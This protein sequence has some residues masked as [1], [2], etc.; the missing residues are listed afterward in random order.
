MKPVLIIENSKNG[1]KLNESASV[2]KE[3][4]YILEGIFTEFDV[5]N[6]NERIY[7]ADEYVPHVNEMMKKK[8]WGVIYGE[9]DHPDVFD[10]SMKYVS[11]TVE[12]AW[13]NKEKNRVDGEI[14]LLNTHYGKDAQSLV[15]D[16]CPVFVSSRAAGVTEANGL[17]KLKQ[18]FTYDI[19]ADPGFSSAR[20]SVKTINESLGFKTNKNF[21]II[22][23]D[24]KS[25][26]MLSE[27]YN[28]ASSMDI[29]TF[30]LSNDLKTEELFKM[31]KNDMIT[32]RQ[33][34]DYTNHLVKQLKANEAKMVKMIKETKGSTQPKKG[35][36]IEDLVEY[37]A[38]I[39]EQLEKM[40]QYM[41]YLAEKVQVSIDTTDVLEKKTDNI[42]KY[43][44]YIAEELDTNIENQVQLNETVKTTIKYTNYLAEN[45][46][47]TIEYSN[48]LAES[49]DQ[50]ID[51]SNYLAESLDQSIDYSQYIA[52]NL[53]NSIKFSNYIAENLNKA[54]DYSE[55]IAES[56]DTTIGYTEYL[57]ESLDANIGYSE[58]IVE[59]LDS[60]INY[61]DYLSECIDNTMDF[62]NS[63]V[64]SLN[65]KG[66]M[67]TEK[68]TTAEQFLTE[69]KKL[70]KK[71]DV[72][73]TKKV[74]PTL[75]KKV[76]VKDTKKV[77]TK[78]DKT[79]IKDETSNQ[80]ITEKIAKLIEEAKKREA[81]K[82]VRPNFY[83]FLIPSDIKAFEDLSND[84]QE[85]IKVA[86]NES[87]GYY[88]RQD[89]IAIMKQV[90]EAD[91]I[92]D[93]ELLIQSMPQKIKKVWEN[94]DGKYKKSILSQSKLYDISTKQLCENFWLT[95]KLEQ[96]NLNEGKTLIASENPFD[97][98]NTLTEEEVKAITNRFKSI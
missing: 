7:T 8:E 12:S 78:V 95:R 45:L 98:I 25:L 44:K 94:L 32:K 9:F 59:Q 69:K 65:S 42:I 34:A 22:E 27:A 19:V 75:S 71:V 52:E 90:L 76:D 96:L 3:N 66:G 15:D 61:A 2:R 4:K 5:R 93:E 21:G 54:I 68:L 36:R 89:V 28:R 87:T 50:S 79:I 91:K 6:R 86:V 48:Y 58:Y 53:D 63:I 14:R 77:D 85:Q 64:E 83:E 56:L 18:L 62:S 26:S 88:S 24:R 55:Y 1:L 82:E 49:L 37:N 73:D 92:T 47:S 30:D 46:D 70:E 38:N 72:K 41:N 67:I 43:T 11:H 17:V 40:V 20:M 13:Y 84:L 31:N 60:T 23:T 81:S 35:E 29:H 57:A 16:G 33:F 80:S 39:Q 97:R 74:I 10:V 51:Y